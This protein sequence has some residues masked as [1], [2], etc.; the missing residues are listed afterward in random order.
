[1]SIYAHLTEAK[2]GSV[3][4]DKIVVVAWQ[5]NEIDL[6]RL[7]NGAPIFLSVLGGLPPHFLTTDFKEAVNPA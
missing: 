5:P 6:E 4:G 7:R 2:S 1:M 3:D